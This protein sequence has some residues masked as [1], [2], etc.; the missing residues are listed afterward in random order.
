MDWST[1]KEEETAPLSEPEQSWG[2]EHPTVKGK[3]GTVFNK[4]E[5]WG[6]AVQLQTTHLTDWSTSKE[7]N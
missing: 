3:L 5:E 4:G 1:K 7:N 6:D 2:T